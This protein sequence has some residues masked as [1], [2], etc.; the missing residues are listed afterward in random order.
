MT[1]GQQPGATAGHGCCGAVRGRYSILSLLVSVVVAVS[2][3]GS[4]CAQS[5]AV[6]FDQGGGLRLD[7]DTRWPDGCGY[8]PVRITVTPTAPIAANRTLVFEFTTSVLGWREGDDPCTVTQEIE[9]PA[10][11]GPVTTTIPIPYVPGHDEYE[12][13]V[14]E[15]G[16][17]ILGL[18]GRGTFQQNHYEHDSP[19]VLLVAD[20]AVDSDGLGGVFSTSF[21]QSGSKQAGRQPLPTF[22]TMEPKDLPS[23]WIDYTALDMVCLS[24]GDL[25]DLKAEQPEVFHALLEWTACGGNL[26]VFDVDLAGERRMVL[27]ALLDLPPSILRETGWR[28]PEL[29]QFGQPVTGLTLGD[30]SLYDS[31]VS[32][33]QDASAGLGQ[34][35]QPDVKEKTAKKGKPSPRPPDAF[36]FAS[37]PYEMGMVVAITSSTPFEE[38]TWFWAWLCNHLTSAQVSWAQRHGLSL[39]YSNPEFH[40]FLVPGVGKPPLNAFRVLITLFVLAIGPVNYYVLRQLRRLHL[41][42]V[43]VPISA[44]GVTLALFAYAVLS[45]GLATRVRVRSVTQ[46]NQQTG[47][48]ECWARLSYYSGLA[49][50]DGLTFSDDIAVYPSKANDDVDDGGHRELL[51]HDG[52]RM[53]TGWL[54]S[55]TPTQ[56]L[57]IRSRKSEIGIDVGQPSAGVLPITNRLGTNVELLVVRDES[58]DLY[59]AS[60]L[61]EDARADAVPVG[62]DEA[63]A[64]L[65]AW[66]EACESSGPLGVVV[67]SRYVGDPNKTPSLMEGVITDVTMPSNRL[68][69]LGPR[70][71]VAIVRFSPEVEVGTPD[72]RPEASLHLVVGSW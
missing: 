34:R 60:G 54:R 59:W 33:E 8:R 4:A 24:F 71:Y 5:G 50:R 7:V 58:R 64:E 70:S 37:R 17:G 28:V 18:S 10:G 2:N 9:L 32:F 65:V 14:G 23:R 40:R 67:P 16:V 12:Y 30:M 42:V 45:D 20:E 48:T 55:R 62:A 66:V 31:P 68:N 25:Q 19:R 27:E 36:P 38:D 43:T 1:G 46:I 52:Q 56:Y 57:T 63:V 26:L 47:Q 13:R 15:G 49:P 72:A 44:A 41:L 35:D 69:G 22:M 29:K 51:W 39:S 61:A 6:H 11:T 53:T 3:T 21:R